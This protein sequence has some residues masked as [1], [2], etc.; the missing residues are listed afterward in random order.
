MLTIK[1][2]LFPIDFSERCCHSAPFVKA[3]ALR[4]GAKITLLSAIPPVWQTGIADAGAI[5]PLDMDEL[6][7]EVETRLRGAF[8]QEFDGIPVQ[9]VVEIGDPAAMITQFAHT[10]GAD[11]IMMPTHGYGPFRTLLLGSVTS[12][13]LH[14]AE[15]LVWTATHMEEQPPPRLNPN[16]NVLCAVD[17]TPQSVPL[18][19]WAAEY[20]RFTGAHL[21]LVHAVSGVV[22][23]P[24]QQLDQE[25]EEK[26]KK[27]ARG[28]IEDLQRSVGMAA[29][30]CVGVGNVANVV[31]AE[32]EGHDSD[33][34]LIGRGI[35][36]ETMG[37]LRTH[38]YGIIRHAP[39][40]VLSV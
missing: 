29:P 13:V 28:A 18:M 23:W 34:I 24:E 11:L 19:Q 3:M 8:V 10:E 4:F 36:H 37:R 20:A 39:C 2:I 33:L 16:G 38:S 27:N 31:R 26:L 30:L 35:L 9:R 7:R 6:K 14:D 22:G 12:K 1:H 40:P 25:L 17:S 15:C 32:A 21:R 5:I